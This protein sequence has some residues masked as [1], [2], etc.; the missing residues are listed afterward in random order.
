MHVKTKASSR[1]APSGC[2]V[3]H[4]VSLQ[5]SSNASASAPQ[6][7]A[8]R[9][10]L[11]RPPHQEQAAGP[12]HPGQQE[13]Q[14]QADYL[15]GD[16][17]DPHHPTKILQ[18]S[19]TPTVSFIIWHIFVMFLIAQKSD[20]D[21][22]A[23]ANLAREHTRSR[24]APWQRKGLFPNQC[25]S[26]FFCNTNSTSLFEIVHGLLACL[27]QVQGLMPCQGVS[28]RHTARTDCSLPTSS[29]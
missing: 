15:Q 17:G 2:A 29:C 26:D 12:A 22:L 10:R 19:R 9:K 4:D 21:G 8:S 18:R 23:K 14:Q 27:H 5:D 6:N 28:G 3:H 7:E 25:L 24:L 11:W 1:C 13:R 16:D 20:M